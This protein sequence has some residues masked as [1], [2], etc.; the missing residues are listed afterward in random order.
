[1]ALYFLYGNS[2]NGKSE[3][4]FQKTAD[5]AEQ[6]PYQR[7]FVVVPEQFTLRAQQSLVAHTKHQVIMNVD[8]VSFDRLAYRVF[9]ELGIHHTVMEETGKSLVLRRIV[10]ENER[11]LTILRG[12]LTR[13]G[14]IGELKSMISELMQYGISPDDLEA[15]LGEL[16]E[17]S[18]LRLKLGDILSVYRSFE[19]YL[20]EGYVTAEKVL[21]VLC[22]AAADSALLKGAVLILDGFTGFTPVQMKLLRELM[23]YVKD[24]RVTVTLDTREILIG[25]NGRFPMQDL[26]YMSHKMV[27]T[28][29]TAAEDTGFEIGEPLRIDAC[30]RSRFGENPVLAHLEQNLFRVR[31]EAYADACGS[32]LNLW[33]L[34][35]PKEELIFA[36]A[37]IQTLV[38]EEGYRYRDFAI[39]SGN[40]QGYEKYAESVFSLYEIPYFTDVKQSILYHPLIELIRAAMEMAERDFS[41]ESVFRYLRTGLCGFSPEETDLLENYCIEK[42]IHGLRKWQKRF[43]KPFARNGRTRPDEETLQDE[44]ALLNQ[45]RERLC[46]QTEAFICVFK[47]KDVS[48]KE[49][50]E[51][52]YQLLCGLEA[53]NKL[54][55]KQEDFEKGGD[56]QLSSAYRQ[57]YKAVID[58]FDK[59]VDLLGDE[60]LSV[61][62]YAD[63]LEAGLASARV[64][65]IPQGN[66]CVILGDIERTR[67]DGIRVLFFLEVNDGVIPRKSQRGSILS[68]YDREV[69]EAHDLEL[70][71]GEREQVFLQR[72]YLYMNL[73]KPSD[74]LYLTYARMDGEGKA[75]RPSYLIGTIRKLFP[76]LEINEAEAGEFQSAVTPR[77]S[78]DAY[79]TDLMR[80][81]AAK[82]ADS[83]ICPDPLNQKEKWQEWKALHRWFMLHPEWT[84]EIKALFD[85]H[86]QNY[87]AKSLETELAQLLYGT[88]LV[89]S[90]TRLELFAKCAYAHFL[91]YGLKLAER[92]E[93][94]FES[95]DMGTMFHSI[96][97]KYCVS[98]EKTY[99][100]DT[101]TDQQQE[102]L[103]RQAMEEAV[104]EMPNESLLESSRSAYVLER[105]YRIMNRSITVMTE[106]IRRGDFRPDGYEVEFSQVS[107]I[108]P[109]TLMRTVGTVDRVDVYE[110][111]DKMYVKVVDYKSGGTKFQL[112]SLYYG[113]QLQLV[114]YLNAAVEALRQRCPEKEIVPAGI[115][116]FRL[117]DPMTEGAGR[118]DEE[119]FQEIL[120]EMRPNGLV[121]LEQEVWL[122]MDRELLRNRKSAVV[123][124]TL[125]KDL[126]VSKTGTSAAATEDFAQLR[127]YADGVIGD[128]AKEILG[129]EIRVK[130]YRL[131]DRTGCDFCSFRG[132]CGFDRRIPGYGFEDEAYL[133]DD[134]IWE[135][136]QNYMIRSTKG[137]DTTDCSS[138]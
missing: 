131:G 88:V 39:V 56:E 75:A 74:A 15:F 44:L 62:D 42:G 1:M 8:V 69:M 114:V 84:D 118:S 16:K 111:A 68:P 43:I 125:K 128:A 3:Y 66:D 57:I 134:E 33:S 2:G 101:V 132:M 55:R 65:F 71:P 137:Y 50:T 4:I 35:S 48:V 95:L 47:K 36:A 59:M 21:E 17:G 49:R 120:S 115:L 67:L 63:V 108:G 89:N 5:M 113:M 107:E 52:L 32:C 110:D 11:N 77:S 81:D 119:I 23:L 14:Y 53:E 60:V 97:Q 61:S 129:G 45:L 105:I 76:K 64:G 51:A 116:Y 102:V 38:R 12:N 103:L 112:L 19:E 40:V 90:V 6:S 130:P 78:V 96:L 37:S 117:D 106:Q 109:D 86:F 80:L 136:I 87:R 72:F 7:Y 79:V 93:F 41:C 9:D 121:N 82:N 31:S 83:G 94:T 91:E 70:A 126:T 30:E 22:G 27:H 13:M 92:K 20:G 58:L 73:T 25:K 135:R 133:K 18:A 24:I 122:H 85:A 46:G 104:L 138:V 124:I 29:V 28:L 54:H 127:E 34:A 26:F 99:D 123:P 100:W 10:E 98:L